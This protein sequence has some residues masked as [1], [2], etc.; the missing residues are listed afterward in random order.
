MW[1]LKYSKDMLEYIESRS[2]SSCNIIYI[3]DFSARY[4]INL[5]SKSLVFFKS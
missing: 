4:T 5:D 2:L 3:F 1:I